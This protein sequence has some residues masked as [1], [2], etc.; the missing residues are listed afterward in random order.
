MAIGPR[1]E[2]REIISACDYF[3]VL[4]EIGTRQLESM[5]DVVTLDEGHILFNQGDMPD[6]FY[7]LVSGNLFAFLTNIAGKKLVAGQITP[8]EPVGELSTLALKPRS[9][10]VIAKNDAKLLRLPIYPFKELCLKYPNVIAQ[11]SQYI[12]NR[13]LQ[14]LKVIA[15]ETTDIYVMLMYQNNPQNDFLKEKIQSLNHPELLIIPLN[16]IKIDEIET[17]ITYASLKQ[18]HLVFIMEEWDEHFLEIIKKWLT[19]IYLI[20]NKEEKEFT[21]HSK[22]LLYEFN[23]SANIRSELIILHS[24]PHKKIDNTQKWLE[25]ADFNLH[26]HIRINEPGDL[27]RLIRFMTGKAL[28]L[29]LGGGGAKGI[30]HLGVIKAL[31]EA[32]HPIDAIGGTSIGAAVAA[33]YALN[34]NYEQ[35]VLFIKKLKTASIKATSL[36]KMV[37]PII[38]MFSSEP[39]TTLLIHLLNN[40]LIEDL[41]IPYFAVASNIKQKSAVILKRGLLWEA[42][43]SS[44]AVPGL[45]PPL[46]YNGQLFADGGLLNNLPVDFM[47]E[48]VGNKN[49]IIAS[50]LSRRDLTKTTYSFPPTLGLRQSLLLKLGIGKTNYVIPP[51]LE[52]FI[53]ALLLGASEREEYNART[54]DI[55]V[56]PNFKGFRTFSFKKDQNED[57]LIQIGYEETL[58]AI[59]QFFKGKTET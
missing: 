38:A 55:L 19:H 34:L 4:P 48:I 6:Y 17:K 53:E 24:D 27:A 59:G 11:L 14:T 51:F 12:V 28:T 57:K 13:F 22:L 25:K 3:T 41:I 33:C 26:H 9:M 5:A 2:V 37:W 58:K 7:I 20:V 52:T 45:F 35:A 56:R 8:Y 18:C 1:Q 43:R 29:V 32:K 50:S 40:V 16:K 39:A 44:V 15:T 46:V 49:I 36:R 42:V 21:N 54:A 23:H 31:L 30:S 10:T 47:R